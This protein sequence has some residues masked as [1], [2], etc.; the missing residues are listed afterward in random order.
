MSTTYARQLRAAR[1][2]FVVTG[3]VPE[4]Y[5][6]AVRPE[7]AASWA[8]SRNGGVSPEEVHL[9][10][11]PEVDEKCELAT[12]AR[13]VLD[14]LASELDD[15]GG[16]VFLA[17][18]QAQLVRSWIP[19]EMVRTS[20]RRILAEPG[21]SCNEAHVGTNGIGT[22]LAD[23]QT[24]II[25]GPEHWGDLH[26]DMTCVAAPILHPVTRRAAGALNVTLMDQHIHPALTA[27]VRWGIEEIRQG[28][29]EQTGRA[30]R[31]L[32]EQF[33]ARR[34]SDR[35]SLLLSPRLCIADPAAAALL[36]DLD[37]A[38][39]WD[40][41]NRSRQP[42]GAT[43]LELADGAVVPVNVTPVEEG[44]LIE[45]RR[46]GR[47]PR[48]RSAARPRPSAAFATALEAGADAIA[49][50]LPLLVVGEPG[51]GKLS[52]ARRLTS[53]DPD[54]DP[55]V[56]IDCRAHP[57]EP[58]RLVEDV[59]TTGGGARVLVLRHLDKIGFRAAKLLAPALEVLA[60][61][62]RPPHLI[63][64]S[65]AGRQGD[66]LTVVFE[67][68]ATVTVEVPPL[69]DRVADLPSLVSALTAGHDRRAR[70]SP[71][72]L[73]VLGRRDWP[74]NVRELENVV[75]RTLSNSGGLIRVADL[76]LDVRQEAGRRSF[77]RMERAERDAIMVALE[78]SRGNKV[79]AAEELGISRSSLY[80]KIE[81]YGLADA[82]QVDVRLRS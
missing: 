6:A 75:Q 30:E 16:A 54:L 68:F 50:G 34:R 42:G 12:V 82:G 66:V 71:E 63:A 52:L 62:P 78:N 1:D 77:T 57:D 48:R 33:M 31:L 67:R 60:S 7:I 10:A 59:R 28:L 25:G 53:A 55:L 24:K 32:F 79:I 18:S 40:Q 74:G 70:W 69:R 80:R 44:L 8:R 2:E 11:L 61:N 3:H 5:R 22:A 58:E 49:A 38:E 17:N 43:E 37:A 27:L 4:R 20:L 65:T 76:P 81:R 45:V 46:Q 35:P 36:P 47:P 21:A 29:L 15:L 51:V 13:P 39:L 23:G 64:T 56:V 26:Q 73:E 14:R 41:V 72:A 19:D 9:P